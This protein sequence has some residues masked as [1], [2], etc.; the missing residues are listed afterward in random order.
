MPLHLRSLQDPHCSRE[1]ATHDEEH[2][3]SRKSA[4][5]QGKKARQIVSFAPE[6]KRNRTKKATAIPSKTPKKSSK[7]L[8][9]NAQ[10]F[11]TPPTASRAQPSCSTVTPPAAPLK[12]PNGAPTA[13]YETTSG[14][15]TSLEL[16]I[17]PTNTLQAEHGLT[18]AP[19]PLAVQHSQPNLA[20]SNHVQ[21][22]P[23][24]PAVTPIN[25]VTH[26]VTARSFQQVQCVAASAVSPQRGAGVIWGIINEGQNKLNNYVNDLNLSSQVLMG[27]CHGQARNLLSILPQNHQSG[28]ECD[29]SCLHWLRMLRGRSSL[30]PLAQLMSQE[31]YPPC[32]P[33]VLFAAAYPRVPPNHIHAFMQRPFAMEHARLVLLLTGLEDKLVQS[34]AVIQVDDRASIRLY[35]DQLSR[36]LLQVGVHPMASEEDKKLCFN[37]VS[38]FILALEAVVN[39]QVPKWMAAM[40]VDARFMNP[41]FALALL[42]LISTPTDPDTIWTAFSTAYAS[43]DARYDWCRLF[44][45]NMDLIMK[46]L[47]PAMDCEGEYNY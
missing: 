26:K 37:A 21:A 34:R 25:A 16:P 18:K 19:S 17:N 42:E 24:A 22:Q 29:M 5:L 36:W 44:Y 20:T 4:R 10:A 43:N 32:D 27:M 7:A 2:E 1:M 9:S 41:A 33:K 38:A 31:R 12:R 45:N 8:K 14:C 11:K 30:E 6:I 3:G 23:N 39:E 35:V 15:K 47:A 13:S 40:L 46:S 28:V